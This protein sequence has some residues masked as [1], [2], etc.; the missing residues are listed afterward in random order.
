[1]INE[2]VYSHVQTV[3]RSASWESALFHR[4]SDRSSSR[5]SYLRVLSVVKL[6]EVRGKRCGNE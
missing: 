5:A 2:A 6:F 1:M 3:R 4:G